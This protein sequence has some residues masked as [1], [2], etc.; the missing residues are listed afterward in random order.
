MGPFYFDIKEDK[1]KSICG[2]DCDVVIWKA[3]IAVPPPWGRSKTVL[4]ELGFEGSILGELSGE[5][6]IFCFCFVL[7]CFFAVVFF[8]S[9]TVSKGRGD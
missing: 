6:S 5:G 9:F 1:K 2:I 7:S 3:G 4:Q 8:F